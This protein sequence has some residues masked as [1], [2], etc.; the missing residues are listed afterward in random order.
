MILSVCE[1]ET[2]TTVIL[3]EENL[4]N[5]HLQMDACWKLTDVSKDYIIY[6][7]L[8]SIHC[9]CYISCG[10]CKEFFYLKRFACMV[11]RWP[12]W[13]LFS[14]P[15]VSKKTSFGTTYFLSLIRWWKG[16]LEVD[17]TGGREEER[18]HIHSLSHMHICWNQKASNL[19]LL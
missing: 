8:L 10:N 11:S 17:I 3:N 9:T 1:Y 18:A 7:S 4:I 15:I 14:A 2:L 5:S 6:S 12:A 16:E 19:N 13:I